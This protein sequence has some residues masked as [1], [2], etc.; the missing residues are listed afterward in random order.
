MIIDSYVNYLINF[1]IIFLYYSLKSIDL[2]C[3]KKL[4][5]KVNVI[6]IIAK[7][8][9]ISKSELQKFKVKLS[10]FFIL[11]SILRSSYFVF[12]AINYLT[13]FRLK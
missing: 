5:T 11:S 13:Y 6:P 10:F 2:V 9:T 1:I 8:D 12:V 4:D 3:M 7:A